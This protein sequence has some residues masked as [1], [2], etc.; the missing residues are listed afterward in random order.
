MCIFGF[1]DTHQIIATKACHI[2]KAPSTTEVLIKNT[3]PLG[4][5]KGRAT[6]IEYVTTKPADKTTDAKVTLNENWNQN[7]NITGN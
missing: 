2:P 3:S 7:N 4:S 6:T 1:A 5:S